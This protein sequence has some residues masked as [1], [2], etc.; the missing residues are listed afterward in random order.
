[1]PSD[2]HFELKY[3]DR[4]IAGID[5]N[6]KELYENSADAM[7]IIENGLFIDCN[8]SALKLMGF[9][10]KEQFINCDP[11][12]LS[13]QFQ[14]D[15]KR[16][17]EKALEMIEI[18]VKR[19]SH[20]FEWIHKNNNEETFPAEVL[21]TTVLKS[22]EKTVFHA[23]VRDISERK[24]AE[25][26]LREKEER[27]SKLFANS[28]E[29]T[30][31]VDHKGAIKFITPGVTHIT[32]YTTK[33]LINENIFDY[34]HP[35]NFKEALERFQYRL[36]EGGEGEYRTF[37]IKTKNGAFRH[38]RMITSNQFSDPSIMGFIINAQDVTDIVQ[39][40]KDKYTAIFD[41]KENERN[42]ISH[43]LHDGLGQTIAAASLYMNYLDLELK[44]Q[45]DKKTH[46]IF[47]KGQ[48]LI[49]NATQEA[50]VISHNFMPR[51]LEA[52]G[53][54]DAIQSL[55]RQ[56]DNIN[57]ATE[58]K[59]NSNI[60]NY[61]F[62]GRVELAIF[63]I[64][65]ELLSNSLKHARATNIMVILNLSG[66]RLFIEVSDDG[67]GFDK[68]NVDQ[69]KKKGIGLTGLKERI[70]ALDGNLTIK[71]S[72]ENGTSIHIIIKV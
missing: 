47:K 12:A 32:G 66:D 38:L 59:L 49:M 3:S 50:R 56:Y 7:S 70:I 58:L 19:G 22:A 43:D 26:K 65:Q 67:I 24:E 69:D 68:K 4:L 34:L 16:S 62:D 54:E 52:Y 29:I 33:E 36:K 21:L 71:S 28:L 41:S 15:G 23:N 30:C 8:Q 60:K 63:R 48:K 44:N 11:S 9:S 37:R 5:L 39:A 25:K 27:L 6:F 55:L 17:D 14:A 64:I 2:L 45:I 42:R 53:L 57:K 61:R 31:I 10:S 20:R 51:T 72:R 18:A 13:P 46:L 40:E 35:E 1:M